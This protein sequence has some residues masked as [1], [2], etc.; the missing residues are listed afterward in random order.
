MFMLIDG[1]DKHIA[2]LSTSIFV[3]SANPTL[4]NPQTT[5]WSPQ[6]SSE[7]QITHFSGCFDK[8][9]FSKILSGASSFTT[10]RDG[11]D[12]F[13][14]APVYLHYYH[15]QY[16][17]IRFPL[18]FQLNNSVTSYAEKGFNAN[19]HK[20]HCILSISFAMVWPLTHYNSLNSSPPDEGNKR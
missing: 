12:C 6:T 4:Q 8:R 18:A 13:K 2:A 16:N 20:Y 7:A 14:Q 9:P 17:Y 19:Q 10:L 1:F 5:I 3:Y 15:F 11:L